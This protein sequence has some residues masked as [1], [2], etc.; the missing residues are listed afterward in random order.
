[1]SDAR[2]KV[3][4][5]GATGFVGGWL[6][7]EL[8]EAGHEPVGAPP[9]AEL[10]IADAAAV[11]AL[12]ERVRPDVIVH[13]AA[14]ASGQK[15]ARDLDRAVRTNIGGTH[16][17]MNAACSVDPHPGVLVV[18]SAEVYAPPNGTDAIDEAAPI[19]PRTTYGLLKLAQEAIA[20]EVALAGHVRMVIARPFN[21]VGPGQPPIAA[22]PSFAERIAAVRRGAART[23]TVGNL[24]VERDIADV[25]DVA[26]AYRLMCEGLAAGRLGE[27]AGTLNVST[28]RGTRLRDVVAELSRLAGVDPELVVD[29][30]LVRPDEPP[31]VVGDSSRLRATTGWAPRF[32]TSVTLADI[33]AAV[34]A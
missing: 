4:V 17:V 16:A 3:L 28:G 1:M 22:I 23:M 18:S 13:L 15:A 20:H 32:D 2:V 27:P 25:R 14:V 10:D 34:P 33:L 19:G 8:R 21:H 30:D 9:S 29:P 31:R 11:R 26:A 6:V 7:A 24:D 12:V 5:T